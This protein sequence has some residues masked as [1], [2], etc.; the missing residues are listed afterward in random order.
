MSGLFDPANPCLADRLGPARKV[1]VLAGERAD[2]TP[3]RR[4]LDELCAGDRLAGYRVLPVDFPG[5]RPTLAQVEHLATA[6]VAAGLGRKDA[7]V[8][9]GH[10]VAG[11]AGLAAA[12]LLRRH[13]RAVQIVGDL[14]AAA[15]AVRSVER[16]TL[17]Q[18]MSVRRKEVSILIDADRVLGGPDALSPLAATA[19]T[20]SRRLI[21][22]VEFLDGV[23]SR[24]DAGLSS[25][26]PVHGQVLAVVD[27]F[28]PGVLADVE[29]FLADQ[30]ARGVISRVRTI[31]LTSSPSTKRRELAERLLAEADRMSLGPADLVIG[32]GGGAVLDLVG[33][34]ALLRGGSTPYLRI[35]TTLVG[36]I[37]AGIGLKVG[38]DA[39]GRKNL[40]GGYHPPV[41][42]LCDLAFLRTLPRQELRCGLSEAIKI[43]AVTD[44]ALF[45]M[46]ETHHGTLLD[47]PVTASTAQIVRQAIVAMQRELAANPFEEEVCRLPDFGHEFGHLLEVA[48]GYRLRHGEA[49]AVGM[50]LAGALAV[51]SGRLAE[52]EYQ[53][54][55]ALLTGAGLPVIDPLCTPGRLWRWLRE[56][57]SAHKGGA[58][59]LVIP[60]AIGS[61]GFIHTIE[62]L[63]SSML[64]RAC[65]RLSGV[66]S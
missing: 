65:R 15:S 24:P 44:P 34:V 23:F 18:G 47:G 16:L 37:D 3:L 5:P 58:P 27:A 45:S 2:I 14:T 6:A 31:P 29:A 56:D 30:R 38:V 13:T 36:M 22:H 63:T 11:Q 53:R 1:V 64:K 32:V 19:G 42:C 21:S 66:T 43:A 39:A 28:S 40:L 54:F 57:I 35:P 12:A 17:G 25:W 20:T 50:A 59:H 48:S 60:T 49:V 51:E 55:L 52:P 33:T 8:V 7:F 26:L 62:E 9:V 4:Y 46:L 10:D 61:G 41:A